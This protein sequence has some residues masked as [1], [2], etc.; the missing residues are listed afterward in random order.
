MSSDAASAAI[1]RPFKL[2][3][4]GSPSVRLGSFPTTRVGS[5]G[6]R[7]LILPYT[8][9]PTMLKIEAILCQDFLTTAQT[10]ATVT[11]PP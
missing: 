10:D 11:S 4:G 5:A 1:I 7:R 8:F 6:H 9:T 3:T 2:K